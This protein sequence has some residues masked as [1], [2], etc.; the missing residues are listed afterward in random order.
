MTLILNEI[1]LR[2][3]LKD[4]FQIAAA[5]RRIT[6][7][8]EIESPRRKL[9]AI[10]FLNAT[11]SYFGLAAFFKG[12]KWIYFADWLPHYIRSSTHCSNLEQFSIELSETLND[13]IPLKYRKENISGFHLSGYNEDSLPEFWHFSN[14][15]GMSGLSYNKPVERYGKPTSDFLKRDVLNHF[16]YDGTNPESAINGVQIYR[17][18]ELITHVMASEELD[19]AMSKIMEYPNFNMPTTI[20]LYADYVKFKFEI[21]SYIYKHWAKKRII[22]KPIDIIIIKKDGLYEKKK[23][24]WTRV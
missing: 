19:K 18:G 13:V 24:K 21:I 7:G 6:R 17:N 2:D 14:I 15:P 16:N 20:E 8:N 4:T 12:N 11:V 10:P 1:H 5:D 23:G 22:S 3:G 9:F